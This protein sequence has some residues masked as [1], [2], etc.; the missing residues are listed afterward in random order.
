MNYNYTSNI[1]T[2]IYIKLST[3]YRLQTMNKTDATNETPKKTYEWFWVLVAHYGEVPNPDS[4]PEGCGITKEDFKERLEAAT[5]PRFC[6]INFVVGKQTYT[7]KAPDIPFDPT[8][9]MR[10]APDNLWKQ[11][12]YLIC[13]SSYDESK[14]KEYFIHRSA[15]GSLRTGI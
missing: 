12:V 11:Y 7:L 5:D 14:T 3:C 6:G 1:Y 10:V 15:E 4:I 8:A 9:M 2:Y 13:L